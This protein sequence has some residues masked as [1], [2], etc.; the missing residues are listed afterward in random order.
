MTTHRWVR[1]TAVAALV[2]VAS[3]T[4]AATASPGEQADAQ[5]TG[6]GAGGEFHAL[7]PYRAFDSRPASPINVVTPGARR[8]DPAAEFNVKLAGTGTLPA[9]SADVLAVVATVTVVDPTGAGWLAIRPSGTAAPKPQSSLVNFPSARNV[10][11]L[12][13]VGLGADGGVTITMGP[14][15]GATANVIVDVYGFI[16]KSSYPT[17]GSRLTPVGPARLVD[18]RETRTPLRAGQVRTVKVR[19]ANSYMP[20]LT[21]AVPNRNTVTAAL[22]NIAAVNNRP[23]STPTY[24]SAS[25]APPVPPVRTSNVNVVAGQIKTVLAVVP[26]VDGNIYVYNHGGETDLIVDIFGYFE[27]NPS[28]T[29]TGRIVPLTAPFRAFDTRE[30]VF[31]NLPLGT[32]MVED[33]SFDAF[34]KSVSL[35]SSAGVDLSAQAAL[36]GNLTGTDLRRVYP[37][38]AAS[39]YLT[40]YPADVARPLVAN[41]NVGE[42]EVVPNMSLIRYSKTGA[43]NVVKMYNHYGSMHY[44]LDV[45]AIVLK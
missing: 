20:T 17:R 1:R 11:N 3:V 8:I 25:P 21:P 10:S 24:L 45:Y 5:V 36:I 26:V 2:A 15:S 27:T 29:A 22:V 32:G 42:G 34:T 30:A 13:V 16:S 40:G 28:D 7:T 38:V 43:P 18:T 23:R 37:S 35:P 31:G 39:T 19:G 6:L 44:L 33:W 41:L 4:V 9:A 12:A 14:K